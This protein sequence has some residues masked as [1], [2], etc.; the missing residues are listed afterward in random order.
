MDGKP[1]R[2]VAERGR[3]LGRDAQPELGWSKVAMT[4]IQRAVQNQAGRAVQPDDLKAGFAGDVF[5]V[6]LRLRKYPIGD[7]GVVHHPH[8]DLEFGLPPIRPAET[9]GQDSKFRFMSPSA[10]TG[11]VRAILGLAAGYLDATEA[12]LR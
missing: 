1:E 6:L 11:A 12:T 7:S 3:S 9:S 10:A 4:R 8:R 2:F 5:R